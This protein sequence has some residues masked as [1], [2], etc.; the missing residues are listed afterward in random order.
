MLHDFCNRSGKQQFSVA[1][2]YQNER[3]ADHGSSI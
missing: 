2:S 1:D 3:I